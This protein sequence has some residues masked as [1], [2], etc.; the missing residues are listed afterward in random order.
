MSRPET[1]GMTLVCWDIIAIC[2]L[3]PL[4]HAFST[5]RLIKHLSVWLD[6]CWLI[7]FD[8]RVNRILLWSWAWSCRGI[9]TIVS[10][11]IIVVM[12]LCWPARRQ[13]WWLVVLLAGVAV[14]AVSWYLQLQFLSSWRRQS[15]DW[16]PDSSCPICWV[17]WCQLISAQASHCSH[18]LIE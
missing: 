7:W 14:S 4:W 9:A 17:Q 15:F 12:S 13:Q 2:R 10:S 1:F 6:E 18:W 16:N 11:V 8:Q 3:Q 5:N